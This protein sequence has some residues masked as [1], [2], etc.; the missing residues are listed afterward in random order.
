MVDQG[1]HRLKCHKIQFDY[2]DIKGIM[3]LAK[4]ELSWFIV[5]EEAEGNGVPFQMFLDEY[6]KRQKD[7]SPNSKNTKEKTDF[8]F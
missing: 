3:W 2:G 8:G 7:T 1:G 4:D 6:T 5:K